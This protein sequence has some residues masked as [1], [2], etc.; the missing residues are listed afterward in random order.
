VQNY[1]ARLKAAFL[2]ESATVLPVV[3]W[4]PGE[5]E[6]VLVYPQR[7]PVLGELAVSFDSDEITILFGHRGYHHHH[8]LDAD[9][10]QAQID[11]AVAEVAR[12][13][14][15]F[16]CALLNDAIVFRWGL[17]TSGTYRRRPPRFAGRAWRFLTPWVSEAVWSGKL[18]RSSQGR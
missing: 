15:E 12:E 13:A 7:S 11:E 1:S 9:A 3:S 18:S 2:R 8:T 17:F 10:T 16:L 4:Q 6:H 14:M 5:E